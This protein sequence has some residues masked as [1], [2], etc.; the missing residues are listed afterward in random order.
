MTPHAAASPFSRYGTRNTHMTASNLVFNA[1]IMAAAVTSNLLLGG[2]VLFRNRKPLVN[3]VFLLAIVFVALF[4]Y[5]NFKIDTAHASEDAV[6]WLEMLVASAGLFT[7]LF[8]LFILLFP[9]AEQRRAKLLRPLHVAAF[10]LFV[11]AIPVAVFS[12]RVFTGATLGPSGLE[13]IFTGSLY[14]PTFVSAGVFIFADTILLFRK[15][16]HEHVAR[17]RRQIQYVLF[18]WAAFIISIVLV[19]GVLPYFVPAAVTA[20]K[21]IPLF[22]IFLIGPTV[23]AIVRYQLMDIRVVIQ[24]GAI[25]TAFIGIV[26]ALYFGLL[27][28]LGA[29][30]GESVA[31]PVSA[32]LAAAVVVLTYQPLDAFLRRVTDRLL[33]KN[34]YDV[35]TA[36]QRTGELL[37]TSLRS[38]DVFHHFAYLVEQILHVEGV[39]LLACRGGRLTM[40][41][42]HHDERNDVDARLEKMLTDFNID[43]RLGVWHGVGVEERF[44]VT[45]LLNEELMPVAD[46]QNRVIREDRLSPLVPVMGNESF[47][48]VIVLGPKRSGE[49]FAPKDWQFLEVATHQLAIA[50]ENVDFYG[51]EKRRAQEL[52]KEVLRRTEELVQLHK[53][54]MQ[55]IQDLSHGLQTPLAVMRNTIEVAER[56]EKVDLGNLRQLAER[57]TT[58]IR[59]LLRTVLPK[60]EQ[61]EREGDRRVDLCAVLH[62]LADQVPIIAADKGLS[63]SASFDAHE[64]REGCQGLIVEGDR[65]SLQEALLELL[66]NAVKYTDPGGTITLTVR[67]EGNDVA[68]AIADTGRGISTKDLPHIF[69]RFHR[70]PREDELGGGTGLGLSIVKS[71]VGAHHGKIA[72]ASEPGKGSTFTV[73][74]PM[75][76]SKDA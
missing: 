14:L 61:H 17:V 43:C 21:I 40:L 33:Y 22:S 11:F 42:A 13:S 52:G 50:V 56:G 62:D 63:F 37:S 54:Q 6:F 41:A 53:V 20:S 18:G 9:D 51:R 35:A 32:A 16:A 48:G 36:V 7:Y 4:A 12:G 15:Y 30:L 24:T 68:V 69:E 58:M 47:T 39:H 1:A 25:Y 45:K 27:L 74:L 70:S 28:L 71:V 67:Q 65:E 19:G 55:L 2:I 34:H 72:V 29:L 3:K 57:M 23:Y 31:A 76:K 75:H 5:S 26:L 44:A 73:R 38:Q 60:G 46:A 66:A 49:R 8:L 59:R 10:G 64:G